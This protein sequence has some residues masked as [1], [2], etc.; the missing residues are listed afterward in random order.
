MASLGLISPDVSPIGT[1]A[2]AGGSY[3]STSKV[4]DSTDALKHVLDNVFRLPRDNGLRQALQK[5]NLVKLSQVLALKVDSIKRLSHKTKIAGTAVE[6]KLL[7]SEEETLYALQGFSRFKAS[8][9]GRPPNPSD[10][11]TVT[12]D[13]F[14]EYQG[15]YHTNQPVPASISPGNFTP[16]TNIP[17]NFMN[18]PSPGALN[19]TPAASAPPHVSEFATFRRG[20]K[21]DQSLFPVLKDEKDWDDWQRRVR[22]QATAQGVEDVLDPNYSPS[23]YDHALFREQ[24]KYMMAVFVTCVQTDYGKGLIRKYEGTYDAQGLFLELEQRAKTSTSAIIKAAELMAYVTAARLGSNTWNGTTTSFVL[25]WEEQVR[26]YEFYAGA[27]CQL[28]PSLKS[29]LLQNAVNSISDLRQVKLNADQLFQANGY[30]PSYEDYRD[31]LLNACARYDA[32]WHARGQRTPSNRRTVYA[33]DVGHGDEPMSFGFDT[34]VEVISA[35][36]TRMSG[37]QWHNLSSETQAKWDSFPDSEKEI[38]L[39][40]ASPTSR[41]A[42]QGPRRPNTRPPRAPVSRQVHTHDMYPDH[43]MGSDSDMGVDSPDTD[44]YYDTEETADNDTDQ[45][46]AMATNRS[47]PPSPAGLRNMMSPSQARGETNK[48]RDTKHAAVNST[49]IVNACVTTY[50]VSKHQRQKFGESLVDRGANGGLAGTD[51]RVISTSPHRSVHVEGID[52]HQVRDVPIVTAGGVLHTAQGD[53]IGIFHQYAHINKGTSIHSSV[54]LEAY[55]QDVNDRSM[56]TPGGLQRILTVDG[57][58]MPLAIRNGLPYLNIR[59]FTDHEFDTLPSVVMTS[60]TDWDPS[61]LDCDPNDVPKTLGP[62]RNVPPE[63]PIHENFN[64]FGEYIDRYVVTSTDITDAVLGEH[65]LPSHF[66]FRRN[67]HVEAGENNGT[68]VVL[69]DGEFPTGSPLQQPRVVSDAEP[70][71]DKL[72]PFFAYQPVEAIKHTWLNSTQLA[73]VPMSTHL[74]RHFKSPFPAHNVHRRNEPIA[75]D[76]VHSNTP[77]VDNGAKYAQFFVGTESMVCDVFPMKT[78]KQFVNTLEDIIRRRGAPTKLVSDSA[79]VEISKKVQDILRSLCID[80]W[81]SEPHQQ[82]QNPAERRYQTVKRL[83]STL[84]DRTGA[85]A[86]TWFLCMSYVCFVINHTAC[87]AINWQIPMRVLTGSTPDISPILRFSFYQPVYYATIEP[88]FPS[89]SREARG[90]FVGVAEHVGH[91]MTFKILT[92]DTN[93]IIERSLVRAVDTTSPNKRVDPVPAEDYDSE[94]AAL[95]G[96]SPGNGT[97]NGVAELRLIDYSDLIGR[98]FLLDLENGERTRARVQE[99]VDAVEDHIYS[100]QLERGHVKFKVAVGDK[101]EDIMTYDQIISKV[102]RELDDDVVWKFKRIVGHEGPLGKNHDNYKGSLYNVMIEWENGEISSEPLS[103]IAAD[104]PVTCAIYARDNGLLDLD[105]WKRFKRLAKRQKQLYRMANQAKLRSYNSAPKFKYG[106]E[107]PRD[108]KH[109]IW[110]DKRNGNSKWAEATQLEMTQL[111]DYT[112]FK[113]VGKVIPEG[114][115]KIRVHLVYDVKHDG[116][117]K[118]RLVADGHLTDIPLESVYSGVVSLRGIRLLTFI[119]ELN[120]LDLWATD[121]GNAYLEANTKEKVCILAGPEFGNR[122]GHI[123]VIHKA[124]YGLRTSGL[125]WHERFASCLRDEGFFPCK[126]EP[127]IW[128]RPNGDVYEYIA[129]YVDDLAMAMLRP[130]EF[131]QLLIDKYKFKLKGTGPISFH[132]GCDFVRDDDGIL[133]L[134]PR[135]YIDRMV[136]SY[137]Q[138]F[139]EKP[140]TRVTSPL[141]KNDHPELDD[142]DLCD[143]AGIRQYQSVVGSLQWAISLGRIDITTAVMTLSR[144]RSMPRKGHLDRAKRVVGYLRKMSDACIRIRTHEPDYSSIPFVEYDWAT[145]VYGE[146]EELIPSDAPPPKGRL[147]TLTHYVDA[148]LYH[149]CLTGRSV[150]GILHFINATPIDWFSKRQATVETATY[151]SEFVAARTCV[152]QVIDLRNTLR[153]LGVPIR[154]MSWMFGDNE[155]VVNSSAQPHAKLHKRHTALSF[156]RVREAIAAKIVGFFHIPGNENPADILSKHWGYQQVWQLL[157][158]LLFWQGD[159]LNIGTPSPGDD[160][161][162]NG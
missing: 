127:D 128:L 66:M 81:Q 89:E 41:P 148:N 70:D 31:L 13:E 116:R 79:Q 19:N 28:S 155:S 12:E 115:K 51:M 144:F 140:T 133:C 156:H 61:V 8:K 122:E 98:S 62:L 83:T 63:R 132:L 130:K 86:D 34:P 103:V 161:D 76:T 24:N 47:K 113:D 88:S 129:V 23:P 39:G 139:G 152:E 5:D 40:G 142:S 45:Y 74:K 53:V 29:A 17:G 38:I 162:D 87:K 54:Q 136:S 134:K 10:W 84:M 73:R 93:K 35:Y 106:F 117:H 96:E 94:P 50:S 4:L 158:P 104:D 99:I 32:E 2:P 135:K 91:A 55:K 92:D 111:D 71:Y 119:S 78:D 118:A 101:Y 30:D 97:A 48:Q 9:L 107:V 109:A 11:C 6:V 67:E 57:Y 138:M 153:Y 85:S 112:T 56:L 123:L 44:G 145:S 65:V 52:N 90:R 68:Q 20:I 14:D 21:R 58:E 121:I 141:D 37:S 125:R 137:E 59:P 100:T 157:Q 49:R 25:H 143:A 22:T 26:L 15:F 146:V 108:Y 154:G 124:L 75:T 69:V 77:A 110:L 42:R 7:I 27:H 102:E 150:T 18:M 33:T 72:V 131:T 82:H 16:G 114:Y 120:G 159:T 80:D 43:N 95:E 151:G 60:D 1:T 3:S 147:V 126:A 46:L 36:R 105:G 64:Q 160:E 149:D